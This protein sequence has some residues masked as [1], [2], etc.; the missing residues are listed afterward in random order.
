M[1]IFINVWILKKIKREC[2]YGDGYYKS[3]IKGYLNV[4]KRL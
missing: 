4:L 2:R 3:V 1:L